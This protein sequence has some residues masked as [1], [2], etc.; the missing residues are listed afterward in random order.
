MTWASRRQF[1]DLVEKQRA[2]V[3]LGELADMLL[4]RAG[5][6]ALLVAEENG[7]DQRLGQ[8]AAIDDDERFAAPLG[9][10]LDRA[11]HQ[12]LADAGFAFDEH[13]NVRLGGALGEPDGAR[14][15]FRAGDDVAEAEFAGVAPRG[16]PEFVLE[17]IDPQR[18]ADRHLKPLGADRL[19]DE[20]G[21]A[22][23]HGGNDRLDRAMRRLDDRGDRDVALAHPRE[24][25]H[26]VEIG[27]DEI[28]D[29]EI[30]RRPVG[31]LE[32]GERRFARFHALR[33]VAKSSGHRLEKAALD[34]IVIDNE[35]ESGHG[36]PRAALRAAQCADIVASG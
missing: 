6:R 21:R 17:R 15:R 3:G 27:H 12:F 34:G 4:G 25:P 26:A 30:D 7:L 11:R 19:D 36:R 14:H 8:R 28:E 16:A 22:R 29:Q 24:H 35:Y 18:V 9:A 13:G 33:V 10:A 1:A 20:I 31:R 23:A 2:A 32:A 5:E